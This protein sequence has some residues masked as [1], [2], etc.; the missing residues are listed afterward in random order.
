MALP[1]ILSRPYDALQL[2]EVYTGM[3]APSSDYVVDLTSYK[4]DTTT[5]QN[6][7][8]EAFKA[9]YPFADEPTFQ[10]AVD[11]LKLDIA[12]DLNNNVPDE[13]AVQAPDFLDKV[14]TDYLGLV[15]A[16][17]PYI[18]PECLGE[19][20]CEE[21]RLAGAVTDSTEIVESPLCQGYGYTSVQK[22]VA[23]PFNYENA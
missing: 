11:A 7:T 13:V 8:L 14:Y 9:Q 18:C 1:E 6:S 21:R 20:I 19:G 22:Q 15:T 23:P 3:G 10:A 17:L 16:E 5:A 2:K 4:S 12:T